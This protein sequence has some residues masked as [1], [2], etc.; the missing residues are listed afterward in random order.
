MNARPRS[1]REVL[2]QAGV[3]GVALAARLDLGVDVGVGDLDALG[4]GDLREH[5]QGLDP[6]FGV[7]AEVRV[8]VVGGL[9]DGL[10]VGLLGDA[11]A[12]E[13]GAELVVH[14]LDLLVDQHVGQL[15]RRVRDGVLDDLV[16]EAVPGA[17]EG[18]AL[19]PAADVGLQLLDRPEAPRLGQEVVVEVGLDLLA[20][21]LELDA[22]VGDLAGQAR[23]AVVLRER[24]VELGRLPDLEPDE[25]RFE[26][27]ISRSWPRMSG[28]R[29]DVPPSN[30]SP[31]VVPMNEMTA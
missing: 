29:S 26:P 15:D 2:G 9:L 22:E 7:R 17:V 1:D 6:A 4:V 28:I 10:E 27:G 20:Q 11:L 30:G 18:I 19:E 3:A 14:H 23:L 21:L 16:G 5:E 24:D 13:R 8:E 31:S 25:V 12:G